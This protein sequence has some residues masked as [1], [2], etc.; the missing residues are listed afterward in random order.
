MENR[1]NTWN[2][3]LL[4][5]ILLGLV[6]NIIMTTKLSG[7]VDTVALCIKKKS[8]PCAAIPIRYV[9]DEPQCADKLLLAMNVTN[10]RISERN[11]TIM[12][13]EQRILRQAEFVNRT[14][15]RWK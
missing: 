7:K 13:L 8:L 5:L 2:A 4:L 12:E 1:K 3:A 14:V 11:K 15:G 6:A 10:V 9:M